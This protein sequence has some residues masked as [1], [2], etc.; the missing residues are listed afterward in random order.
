MAHLCNHPDRGRRGKI[1]KHL[2]LMVN[3]PDPHSFEFSR[4]NLVVIHDD[5]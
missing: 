4:H 2:S 3:N 5:H 1:T